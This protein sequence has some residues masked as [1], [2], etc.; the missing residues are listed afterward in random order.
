M[1]ILDE[2]ILFFS[3]VSPSKFSLE[4]LNISWVWRVFILMCVWN[5]K[6]QFFQNR[7]GWWLGLA[8]WLSCEFKPR[9]NRMAN[10]DF[11]SF[12]ALAGMT[13]QLLRMLGT[14]A[15]SSSLRVAS[16]PRGPVASPVTLH[17][18]E[19][20]FTL[21]HTLPLYNSHLNTELLIAKIQANLARNKANKMD[22]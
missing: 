16:Y 10:L 6:S 19:H 8:T 14:C 11:L 13:L 20:L 1:K 4:A 22:D 21:S 18:L 17:K 2:S 15:T 9:T 5:A 12:S 3:R 7:A